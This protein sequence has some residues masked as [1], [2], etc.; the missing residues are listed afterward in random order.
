MQIDHKMLYLF[1]GKQCQKLH[2]N[3]NGLHVEQC[4]PFFIWRPHGDS[5]PGYR[6]ERAMS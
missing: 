1:C 3:E 6:R 4:K 5:N 2:L